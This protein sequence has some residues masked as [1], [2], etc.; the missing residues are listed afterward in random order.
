MY[1]YIYILYPPKSPLFPVHWRVNREKEKK[2]EIGKYD[3]LK[4]VDH[5]SC[6]YFY[7]NVAVGFISS[8]IYLSIYLI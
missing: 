2:H 6:P 7:C 4:A 3:A 8:V 1:I 5:S